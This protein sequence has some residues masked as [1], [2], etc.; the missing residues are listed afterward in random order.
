MR[1]LAG[2]PYERVFV[3]QGVGRV[4]GIGVG[5]HRTQSFLVRHAV[6]GEEQASHLG[7]RLDRPHA[8]AV[9]AHE[10]QRSNAMGAVH[11]EL[12]RDHAAHREADDMGTGLAGGVE[13]SLYVGSHLR[14]PVHHAKRRARLACAAVVQQDHAVASGQMRRH[15]IPHRRAAPEAHD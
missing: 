2:Q 9:R 10:R 3:E 8:P 11:G 15:A 7:R 4:A 12:L 6:L 13:H 1:R 5:P 14:D